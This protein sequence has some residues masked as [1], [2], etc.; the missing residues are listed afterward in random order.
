[1]AAPKQGILL[2][3]LADRPGHVVTPQSHQGTTTTPTPSTNSSGKRARNT[4]FENSSLRTNFK[5]MSDS[6]TPLSHI[7]APYQDTDSPILEDLYENK[8]PPAHTQDAFAHA[9][10]KFSSWAVL[11]G[12]L[13]G[14]AVG[15]GLYF[16]QLGPEWQKLVALPGNLF[17]RAL[18]CLIVPMVF[19]VMTVVV[20]E[21][22][23]MGRTSILRVATILPYAL[24]SFLAATQGLL[25]AL[26]FQASFK[27]S[28]LAATLASKTT[29]SAFNMTVR[30][31]NGLFLATMADG[32]V[33][34]VGPSAANASAIFLAANQTTASAASGA[35][36]VG[37]SL[38]LMDQIVAITNLMIPVNIFAS[39]ASGDLISIVL[40][41]I[42]V[43]LAA[44][45]SAPDLNDNAVLK[46]IRQFRT[47]F[48]VMLGWLLSLTPFAVIFLMAAA[49]SNFNSSNI[50]S[51]MSQVGIFF[52]AF[53]AGAG[54]H[55]LVVLPLVLFAFVRVNPFGYLK[56][57]IPAYV[58]AFGCASSMATLPVALACIQRAHVSRTLAHIAMPFGTPI[59]LNACGLFY[60]LAIVFMATMDGLAHELTTT[61]YIVLFLVSLLG[62]M[63]TAPVPNASL[64]YLLTLWKTCFPNHDL[65]ASFAFIVAA[66]FIVDRFR[67]MVNVNGN[68]VVTRILADQ[69]DETFEVQACASPYV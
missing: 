64:V 46:L 43:G 24:T 30:C 60:P 25:L 65:P 5:T 1:M 47:I 42:P 21:A 22:I 10:P 17:L 14:V 32:G 57:L 7:A 33:G 12:A 20:A 3:D 49:V 26:L 38:S 18:R 16:A 52:G 2:F 62:C 67:T 4:P 54:I 27:T 13:V 66:D 9:A 29:T 63:G 36:A 55:V 58:F 51:V 48:I 19:C 56:H 68:A 8:M 15:A 53:V 37:S 69:I 28:D 41:S 50:T 31:A 45:Y 39:L 59:N 23:S 44:A 11:A 61:R 35:A 34:C 6:S 40:F